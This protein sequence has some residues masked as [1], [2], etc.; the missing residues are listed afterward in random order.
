MLQQYVCALK[1]RDRARSTNELFPS[2]LNP[3]HHNIRKYAQTLFETS[4][5]AR[6]NDVAAR[7]L[8]RHHVH[9]ARVVWPHPDST[10]L[11][12]DCARHGPALRR[13]VAMPPGR[14]RPRRKRVE[15]KPHPLSAN[16]DAEGRD[17]ETALSATCARP[18]LHSRDVDQHKC[19]RGS[20]RRPLRVGAACPS[21]DYPCRRFRHDR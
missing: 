7:S 1:R 12:R 5:V 21:P 13:A 3:Q 18:Q 19:A 2:A 17:L 6:V 11:G 4:Y 20:R 10:R 14:K 15:L 9:C 8:R 16:R